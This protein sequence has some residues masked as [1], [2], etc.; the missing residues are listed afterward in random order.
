MGVSIKIDLLFSVRALSLV[1]I[2]LLHNISGNNPASWLNYLAHV[3]P[4]LVFVSAYMS[5]V[6]LL[7][8]TYYS[9]SNYNN[10]LAKPG[11]LLV[12]VCGYI[13]LALLGLITFGNNLMIIF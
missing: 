2:I 8:D 6:T 1:V 5:L 9:Y 4:A 13:L 7:A 10:H 3:V 11:L 12:V